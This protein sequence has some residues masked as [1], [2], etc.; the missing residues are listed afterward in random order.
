MNKDCS[1]TE[2]GYKKRLRQG[3][4]SLVMLVHQDVK[5]CD[6]VCIKF[7]PLSFPTQWIQPYTG[8]AAC[9]VCVTTEGQRA[10]WQAPC[11]RSPLRK[12]GIRTPGS[13]YPPPL[14]PTSFPCPVTF[15]TE[16]QSVSSGRAQRTTPQ[17]VLILT[18]LPNLLPGWAAPFPAL[19][20]WSAA[21]TEAL[22][23]D[24][25][26]GLSDKPPALA[27]SGLGGGAWRPSIKRKGGTNLHSLMY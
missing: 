26:K 23:K 27:L 21:F 24:V 18:S 22:N 10:V 15:P 13:I 4:V 6:C 17:G 1:M 7:P 8:H 16:P 14:E 2:A 19:P 5:Q 25:H 9:F 12:S 20:P 11:R 3:A